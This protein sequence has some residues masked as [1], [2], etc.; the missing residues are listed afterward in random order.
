MNIFF[1]NQ[2][3]SHKNPELRF[4]W[5]AE[6]IWPWWFWLAAAPFPQGILSG[7]PWFPPLTP[8]TL[9]RTARPLHVLISLHWLLW[10]LFVSIPGFE[11]SA[12]AVLS[13]A[14]HMPWQVIQH[15]WVVIRKQNS[16]IFKRLSCN[17]TYVR[18]EGIWFKTF[19]ED[20]EMVY[21]SREERA[22]LPDWGGPSG[23]P[24]AL[25][26]PKSPRERRSN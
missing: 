11:A 14:T 9:C 1:E 15:I 25:W 10:A 16:R 3:I 6:N 4:L 5:K 22:T 26:V 2:S 24:L 12:P 13:P 7:S 17:S 21:I 18:A 19:H 23:V 20:R 8:P